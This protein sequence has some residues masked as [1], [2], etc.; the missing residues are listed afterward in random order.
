MCRIHLG[1]D[2]SLAAAESGIGL[3]P[4]IAERLPYSLIVVQPRPDGGTDHFVYA[5]RDPPVAKREPTAA[6]YQAGERAPWRFGSKKCGIHHLFH[7]RCRHRPSSCKPR[8][9]ERRPQESDMF[10]SKITAAVSA[11]AIFAAGSAA[12]AGDAKTIA[13]TACEPKVPNTAAQEIRLMANGVA[14]YADTAKS[15]V[16]PLPK[17]SIADWLTENAF[18]EAYFTTGSVSGSVSCTVYMGGAAF[19][20]GYSTATQASPV[21][22]A[23]TNGFIHIALNDSMGAG[24]IGSTP[25]S[26]LCTLPPKA[27]LG[28]FYLLEEEAT[29]DEM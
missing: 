4:G 19:G 25:G 24:D 16:C 18:L 22:P 14:N 10:S 12:Q 26:V 7:G 8:S 29:Q 1:Y 21:L 17:D 11:V 28:G 9:P 5:M 27:T 2:D 20:G 23:N 15:V 3:I 6:A 13:A